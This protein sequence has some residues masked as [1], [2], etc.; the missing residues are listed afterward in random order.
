MTEK[1]PQTATVSDEAV[2]AY[3]SEHKDEFSQPE[4][5]KASHIL[6]ALTACLSLLLDSHLSKTSVL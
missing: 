5:R 6:I 3:F 2:D 4:E 1:T